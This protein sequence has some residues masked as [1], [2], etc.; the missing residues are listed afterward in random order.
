VSAPEFPSGINFMSAEPEG[1]TYGPDMFYSQLGEQTEPTPQLNE[2]MPKAWSKGG[3]IESVKMAVVAG[4][5][6]GL[7][8]TSLGPTPGE[9]T[10]FDVDIEYPTDVTKYPSVWVQFSIETLK[11]AGLAMQ[12]VTQDTHGN[13]GPIQEW[14]F[15]GRITL[16][17]AAL[18]SRDRDRLADTV[19]SSLAFSRA[20]D[21]V[22][23]QH[24]DA[25]QDRSLITAIKTTPM[26]R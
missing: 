7:R 16:T 8:G 5:R 24:T 19:I 15:T 22:I 25:Q 21:L 10:L 6:S 23:R 4:I 13:W 9:D 11:R 17:I 18:S 26:W 12:T 14:I 1:V 20:P 3:V 2:P